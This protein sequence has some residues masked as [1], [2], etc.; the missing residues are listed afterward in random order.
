MSRRRGYKRDRG[1]T[2]AKAKKQLSKIAKQ[3]LYSEE[4]QQRIQ[5]ATT[6]GEMERALIEGRHSIPHQAQPPKER[7]YGTKN[8]DSTARQRNNIH[9]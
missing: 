3:L 2:L 8:N 4:I 9:E 5:D 6:Y 1:G 7:K